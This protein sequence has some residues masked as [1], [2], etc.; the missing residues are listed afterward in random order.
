MWRDELP[1]AVGTHWSGPGP[2]DRTTPT[3]EFFA[4]TF[5]VS[6]SAAV[7]GVISALVPKIHPLA[8]RLVLLATGST[9]AI[10]ATQWL[11]SA[12]LTAQAG[13]PRQAVLGAWILIPFAAF[14]YGVLP[15]LLAPPPRPA[16]TSP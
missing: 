5:A 3:Q 7:I 16:H 13:D 14:A 6:G 15:L 1:D 11:V 12:G 8:R 9:S 4:G 10:A 2:A